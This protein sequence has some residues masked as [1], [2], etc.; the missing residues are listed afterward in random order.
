M[1]L[2]SVLLRVIVDESTIVV[3]I[4]SIRIWTPSGLMKTR[5]MLN[6]YTVT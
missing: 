6:N 1:A 3:K 2:L 5:S 4:L